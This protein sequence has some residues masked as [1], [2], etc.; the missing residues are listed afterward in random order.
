M[1]RHWRGEL[2]QV[3]PD[4]PDL[5]LV[6]EA[7]DRPAGFP[8]ER[9]G[10]YYDARG[11]KIQELF[12]ETARRNRAYIVYS[13]VRRD[14][15]GLFR[16]SSVLLDRDG[17]LA[18]VYDKNHPTIPEMEQPGVA[19]GTEATTVDC[20]FGTVGFAICFDLN[21]HPIREQYVRLKPQLVLF[22][23]MYHG[24]LMQTYWAYSCRSYF[25]GAICGMPSE[26]RD[27]YGGIV[28]ASTNYRDFA[29]ARLNLDYC[30]AHLD[31][32]QDKL[33]R[34]KRE[35]GPR[36]RI[37][38]PGFVGSVL[39]TSEDPDQTAVDMARQLDIEL[40]DDYFARSL[41][42]RGS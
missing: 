8:R 38:D 3:L 10:E 36:V 6:Q 28:A 21:F 18:G 13:A 20:D 40:L 42:A 24:G 26:V 29:V 16:N 5:I 19:P 34:L 12:A 31:F 15:Q 14:G 11:G 17:E 30:M 2:E 4:R 32:N 27:P 39:I 25:V 1:T 23:S 7:C 22:S 35:Y 41:A 9:V 33:V 37:H